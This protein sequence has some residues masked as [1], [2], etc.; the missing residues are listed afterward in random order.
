MFNF[1]VNISSRSSKQPVQKPM[2]NGKQTMRLGKGKVEDKDDAVELAVAKINS[3]LELFMGIHD[4][5]LAQTIWEIGRNYL[6]PHEFCEKVNES[7]IAD[8][9]FSEDFIFD[10]WGA[11]ND[12]K[13]GR[14]QP[15]AASKNENL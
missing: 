15:D 4:S 14:L 13:S 9:G 12:A 2:G 10:L 6:N 5:E 1:K 3:L 7:E 11:I 8:F